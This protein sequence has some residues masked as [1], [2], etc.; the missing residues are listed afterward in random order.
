MASL[1]A[2]W[3]VMF[4]GKGME[5]LKGGDSSTFNTWAYIMLSVTPAF[6]K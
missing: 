2:G 1:S 5:E 6:I 4:A 3:S